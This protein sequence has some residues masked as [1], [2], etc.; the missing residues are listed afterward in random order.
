MADDVAD[1]TSA[2]DP[3]IESTLAVFRETV[4]AEPL[5]PDERRTIITQALA[6]L[7]QAYVH[8]PLKR[9]MHAIDPIQRL[10]LLRYRYERMSDRRFHDEMISVFM[11]LRDLHTNYILPDP[12][13]TKTAFLPFLVEEFYDGETPSYVVTKLLAGF[14][15]RHF[16]VG[17]TVHH[18]NGIPF[19]RAVDINADEQAGS[20]EA[21]RHAQGLDALTIRPLSM[22]LP[23]DEDWVVIGYRTPDGDEHQTRF[24]W[25]I[26]QPKASPQGVN[27]D[28]AGDAAA[29]AL[30]INA[31]GEAVRRAKKALF[32]RAAMEA[33]DRAGSFA[34]G[35]AAAAADTTT[36]LPDVLSFR[37]VETPSGAFGYI[38]IWTF[39]VDPDAFVAEVVR[40]LGLLPPGG[41]ILDVRSNG[42]GVITAG[43]KLLQTLTPKPIEPCRLSFINTPFTLALAQTND[44][45]SAW[46]PSIAQAVETGATYSY[47]FPAEPVEEYNRLGQQYCGPVVLVTDAL[48][49]STTDIFAAGYQ[50]HAIGPI[51]GIAGNTGAGGANVVTHVQLRQLEAEDGPFGPLPKNA[52]FRVAIRRTTRVGERSG[53]PLEDLGVV[54]D[55]IHHMT[56]RDVLGSNEDLI[57]AAAEL[58]AG[59]PVRDLSATVSQGSVTVTTAK[60]SRLDIV[61]DGRPFGSMDVTDGPHGVSIPAGVGVIDLRGYDEGALV[62]A[63]RLN[64]PAPGTAPAGDG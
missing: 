56:R 3:G 26:F 52:N 61:F 63:R 4:A 29:R 2:D 32:A 49:Y 30:G 21:A 27:P 22:S 57:A 7:D 37:S 48:C 24:D 35:T 59:G 11:S 51:L 1:L 36:S 13:R 53:V 25:Q 8:L 40:I 19:E 44:F 38:R 17:V 42:G 10:R 41:L 47:G 20:N 64:V 34:A 28:D 5:T 39:D 58:L 55:H 6:L 16:K 46:T 60:I 18:W 15:H 62:A 33:E 54:P 12:Y 50:D 43:E 23:P 31:K 45:L 9:A 14:K